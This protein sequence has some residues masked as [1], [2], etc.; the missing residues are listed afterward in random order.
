MT[1]ADISTVCEIN[2]ANCRQSSVLGTD[3]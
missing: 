1:V 2:T 3:H